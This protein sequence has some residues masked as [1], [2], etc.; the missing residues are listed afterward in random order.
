MSWKRQEKTILPFDVVPNLVGLSPTRLDPAWNEPSDTPLST[1]E[2]LK[3]IETYL[4]TPKYSHIS[5]IHLQSCIRHKQTSTFNRH[6]QTTGDSF[7]HVRLSQSGAKPPFWQNLER[8]DFF[9]MTLLKHQNIKT[10]LC[11]ISNMVGFCHFCELDT[12]HR[13]ITIDSIFG[14]PC[15]YLNYVFSWWNWSSFHKNPPKNPPICG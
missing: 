11:T 15:C 3:L 6:W 12:C 7:L 10:S 14:S 2:H 5:P 4:Y 13:E 1:T 8:Q 9:H